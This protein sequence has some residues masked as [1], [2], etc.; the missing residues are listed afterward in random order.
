MEEKEVSL[1]KTEQV[2]VVELA[3]E[4]DLKNRL[5][6]SELKKIG[7]WVPSS[8]T[9]VDFDI[10][11][12]IRRRL[13]LMIEV[14]QEEQ[15]KA[16]KAKVKKKVAPARRKTIKQLGKPRKAAATVEE[17]PGESPL[18]SCLKPRSPPIR[19][20]KKLRLRSM[21]S[22]SSRRLRLTFQPTF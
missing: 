3:S 22:L 5:V 17:E 18:V 9:L 20:P 7:V 14:E 4:F 10:A 21:T 16:E 1:E 6:I 2:K 19:Y 13:Q 12:R 8:E 11:N 15:V